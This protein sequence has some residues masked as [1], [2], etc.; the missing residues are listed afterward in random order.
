MSEDIGDLSK[1]IHS[2]KG[3]RHIMFVPDQE[4]ADICETGLADARERAIESGEMQS[5]DEAHPVEVIIRS[6]FKELFNA[7]AGVVFVP[8]TLVPEVEAAIARRSAESN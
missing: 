7:D 5:A 8:C 1:M 3:H 4:T 6:D 2:V